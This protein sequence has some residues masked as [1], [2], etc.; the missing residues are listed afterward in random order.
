M[1]RSYLLRGEQ[2]TA[3]IAGVQDIWAMAILYTLLIVHLSL[4][5]YSGWRDLGVDAFDYLSTP[6]IPPQQSVL[7]SD[8]LINVLGYIPLGFLIAIG[9]FPELRGMFSIPLTTLLTTL[10]AGGLEALQTFLPTRV[11]SKLD[12]ATNVLGGLIGAML[13]SYASHWLIGSGRLHR[14]HHQWLEAKTTL[15]SA[16][17][18]LWLFILIAPQPIPYAVGP[19]L[20]DIWFVVFEQPGWDDT[21]DLLIQWL[22]ALEPMATVVSTALFLLGAWSLGLAQTRTQSPRFR[23]L[24]CLMVLTLLL[25]WYGPQVMPGIQND[26]IKDPS[27]LD[28]PTRVAILF[29]V[30]LA[31]LLAISGLHSRY[32]ARI[33]FIALILAWLSSL[34]LPGYSPE[35][36]LP[37][38]DPLSKLWAHLTNA[39]AWMANFWPLLSLY[40]GW[41]LSEF[42]FPRI[43][44][45]SSNR[46]AYA[47]RR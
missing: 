31:V 11:P 4:S 43:R 25:G 30:L 26:W 10:L 41:Q 16:C 47:D 9:L 6:W 14:V 42:R 46:I 29:A 1:N 36:V 7:W 3:L 20:G 24:L 38:V 37:G 33:S 28:I 15:G 23:L 40:I 35:I 27:E 32:L 5:P 45:D 18:V 2:K 19:W 34:A 17:I 39:A 13:A 21:R 22:I 8:I 44:I 12:L